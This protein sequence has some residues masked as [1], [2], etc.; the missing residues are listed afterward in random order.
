VILHSP[1]DAYFLLQIKHYC[2]EMML[3]ML[4]FVT[5]V[6]TMYLILL[7]SIVDWIIET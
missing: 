5:A 6:T 7:D 2:A 4:R 1:R 3:L